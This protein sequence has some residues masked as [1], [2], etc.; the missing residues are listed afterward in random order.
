MTSDH[1]RSNELNRRDFVRAAALGV[2][3]VGLAGVSA[4]PAVAARLGH[5]AQAAVEVVP[6]FVH[7]EV[8]DVI[9]SRHGDYGVVLLKDESK[10]YLPIWIGKFEAQSIRSGMRGLS[11]PR[12]MTYDFVRNVVEA[13]GATAK[14]IQITQLRDM[15]Y[16]AQL[17]LETN[18]KQ[19]TLDT[20]PSD[21]TA[22]AVRM[23]TPIYVSDALMAKASVSESEVDSLEPSHLA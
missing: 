1:R 14:R 11:S 12:P 4:T 13:T 7:V 21:A 10:R 17:I 19:T 20:R 16:Y 22:L 5:D 3:G 2:A 8:A 15:T 18:G 6:H 9:E 23:R